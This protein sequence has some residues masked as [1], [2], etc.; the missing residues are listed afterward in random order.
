M[1]ANQFYKGTLS[2][3]GDRKVYYKTTTK[4]GKR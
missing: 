2:V 3:S 1:L 4:R